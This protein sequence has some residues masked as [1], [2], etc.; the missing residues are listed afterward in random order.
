VPGEEGRVSHRNGKLKSQ[1]A[2]LIRIDPLEKR[3]DTIEVQEPN[4]ED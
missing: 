3:C 4:A 1:T 2:A